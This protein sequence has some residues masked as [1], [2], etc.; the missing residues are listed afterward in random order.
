M[1]YI[2]THEGTGSNTGRSRRGVGGK[3]YVMGGAFDTIYGRV[4]PV[5]HK[6]LHVVLILEIDVGDRL[7]DL[8]IDIEPW[9]RTDD[10]LVL[11][12]KAGS[13]LERLHP[14]NPVSRASFHFR[15]RSR[16]FNSLPRC[17]MPF[18]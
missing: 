18:V 11:M 10:E 7:R 9:M 15:Y 5:V 13:V 1:Y 4:V 8:R 17:S 2:V 14:S 16:T 3:L 6:K 12:R